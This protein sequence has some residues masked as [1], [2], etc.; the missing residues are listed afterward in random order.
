M[1]LNTLKSQLPKE[2]LWCFFGQNGFKLADLEGFDS[3]QTNYRIDWN[4]KDITGD[5]EGDWKKSWYRIGN[6]LNVV[7][8]LFVDIEEQPLRVYV[9]E[10]SRGSWKE[11]MVSESLE[12]FISAM[13][14]IQSLGEEEETFR[15][16]HKDM[17]TNEKELTRFFDTILSFTGYES[18]SFWQGF[19]D[20]HKQWLQEY[21]GY[22]KNDL[23]RH[24]KKALT[25]YWNDENIQAV[26]ILES[27]TFIDNPEALLLLGD[28][29]SDTDKRISGLARDNYKARDC[30]L[31]SH[32]LGCSEASRNL[33]DMYYWGMGK[34]K[35]NRKKSEEFWKV[36]HSQGD[37]MA[38]FALANY[39]NDDKNE[40]ID[41][42]IKLYEE[43]VEKNEFTGNACTNLG[44]I[45]Y[46][47][48]AIPKD[49]EKAFYWSKKGADLGNGNCLMDL[50]RMYYR[51]D[52]VEKSDEKAIELVKKAGR[53]EWIDNAE[54]VIDLIKNGMP[55]YKIL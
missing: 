18:E 38:T 14:Y 45:Y 10:G 23:S 47:G 53:T 42:A 6:D 19:V 48:K 35:Q 3:N 51:G 4:G 25:H 30:W 28:I 8:P 11:N 36:A 24:I 5:E 27:K 12:G 13:E 26:E 17:L 34:I 55:M 40:S 49:F 54:E 1:D 46:R 37:E 15:Y 7:K 50:A 21:E 43:L 2:E 44:R 52:Y 39:Y 20:E 16:P 29:Y 22:T 32:E 33:A 41:E 31:R 9:P